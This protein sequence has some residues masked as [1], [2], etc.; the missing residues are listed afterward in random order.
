MHRLPDRIGTG[1]IQLR[2]ASPADSATLFAL[3]NNW[4]VVKWLARPNWPVSFMETVEFIEA[5]NRGPE[6]AQYWA[7]ERNGVVLGAISGSI[8]PAGSRQSGVGPHIGYWLGEPFWGQGVMTRAASL[9]CAAIFEHT[10]ANTIYSG[11][12]EGNE[13]SLRI[14]QK[15]GF[16]AVGSMPQFCTPR[17]AE[18][19]HINTLLQRPDFRPVA[20]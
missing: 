14:Q 17:N 4:N 13:G 8:E 2:R 3:F 18:L 1:E 6:S 7:I 20:G 11:V 15:L 16:V 10:G 12:F 5:A 9:F 19:A